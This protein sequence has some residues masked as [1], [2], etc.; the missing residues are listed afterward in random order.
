MKKNPCLLI[1]LVWYLLSVEG[2]ISVLKAKVAK[3]KV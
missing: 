2:V 1:V 3:V